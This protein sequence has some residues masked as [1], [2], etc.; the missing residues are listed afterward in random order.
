[1]CGCAR[2]GP[3][4]Q[5]ADRRTIEKVCIWG[6]RRRAR[7]NHYDG[8]SRCEVC[9]LIHQKSRYCQRSRRCQQKLWWWWCRRGRD[10]LEAEE[11]T[12]AYL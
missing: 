6:T 1:Y 9:Q 5:G 11:D 8:G 12:V 10:L 3:G 2:G 4:G 7:N